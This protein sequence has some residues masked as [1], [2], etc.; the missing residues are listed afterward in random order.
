MENPHLK[1]M[2]IRNTPYFRKRPYEIVIWTMNPG[3]GETA[4]AMPAM[5]SSNL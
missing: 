2:I 5:V 4:R 3:M 1:W